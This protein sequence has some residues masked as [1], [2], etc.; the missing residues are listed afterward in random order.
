MAIEALTNLGNQTINLLPI[1]ASLA[2][3]GDC[4]E[5]ER[6]IAI[7]KVATA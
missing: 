4:Q 3:I 5:G 7:I 6:V 1:M 2:Q